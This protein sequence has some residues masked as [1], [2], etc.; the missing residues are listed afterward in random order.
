MKM[1]GEVE[2]SCIVKHSIVLDGC[3]QSASHPSHF[4]PQECV[5]QYPLNKRLGASQSPSEC[6]GEEKNLSLLCG[7]N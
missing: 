6:F 7:I 4:T 3:V 5:P 1:Y 2:V